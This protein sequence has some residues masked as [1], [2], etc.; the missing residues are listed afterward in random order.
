MAYTPTV[1]EESVTPLGPTNMNHIEQGIKE[2]HDKLEPSAL[3]TLLLDLFHPVGMYFETKDASFNP[4]TAWGG[5]WVL[6]QEGLVHVSGGANY[7]VTSNAQD[8]G[9]ATHVLTPEETAI[10]N[11]VHPSVSNKYF[12]TVDKS[13]D[14]AVGRRAIKQGTGKSL[15]NNL[16][17]EN[18]IT[19]T[20]NTGNPPETANGAAHNNMQPYKNVYRW[21]RTE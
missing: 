15:A 4:N 11:H 18:A 9:E 7:P 17:C 16:Y 19:R 12:L 13:P 2:A 21:L 6:E 10:R 8:G 1:W 20:T 14:N 3:A 5:T